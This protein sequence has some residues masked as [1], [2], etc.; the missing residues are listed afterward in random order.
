MKIYIAYRYSA[1]NVLDVL[2]NIGRATKVGL[3]VA[4]LGHFPYIPHLDC[5]VAIMDGSGM[6]GRTLP[7][8]YYY[9]SSMAFLKVCDAL[10]I[11][12]EEDIGKSNGVTA[13]Y[14]YCITHGL[15]I[16]RNLEE[17][18]QI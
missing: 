4:K 17:I 11:I 1:D 16:I 5:L 15:P 2:G 10:Y 8:K 14:E 3:E 13:E 18:P 9:E 12:D 7:K 6:D